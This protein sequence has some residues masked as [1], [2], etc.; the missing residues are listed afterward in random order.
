MTPKRHCQRRQ[1]ASL[2]ST[3]FLARSFKDL[4]GAQQNRGRHVKPER[5]PGLEVEN[6]LNT[7]GQL[8]R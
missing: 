3:A 6:H 4:V 7:S 5:F 8:H 1:V 2:V